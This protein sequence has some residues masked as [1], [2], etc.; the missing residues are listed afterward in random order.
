LPIGLADI[1]GTRA[2]EYAAFDDHEALPHGMEED[3][4]HNGRNTLVTRS[5]DL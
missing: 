5:Q 4:E 3:A 1:V 2:S